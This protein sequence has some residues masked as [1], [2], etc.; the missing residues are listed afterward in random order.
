MKSSPTKI[1]A[2]TGIFSALAFLISYLEFP[3][4]PAVP[5]LKLDFSMVFILLAGFV[6]GPVSGVCAC[7][8]KELFRFIFGSGTFGIGEVANLIVTLS[9][10]LVPT[11]TY[12]YKKSLLSVIV[13]LIIGCALEIGASLLANRFINFPLYMGDAGVSFF[14]ET[15]QYIVLFNLIKSV[16]ISLISALLYKRISYFINKI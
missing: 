11:I 16:S 3:I 4:F 10:I 5:F 2:G 12:K 8:L 1:L 7:A 13:T 6:F 15:W 14:Y 9:F